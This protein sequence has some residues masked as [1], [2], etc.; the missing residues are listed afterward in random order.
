M[1]N[2]PGQRDFSQ[3]TIRALA[4]KGISVYGI[5]ALPGSGD[6]P[7]ANSERGY[8]VNDN[9]CGKV[10]TFGQVREAAK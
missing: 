3:A 8:L 1:S 4:K 10:W 2:Q 9:D 7:Y 5:T 6:M